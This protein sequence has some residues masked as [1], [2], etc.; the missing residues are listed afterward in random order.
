MR[1]AQQQLEAAELA[2]WAWFGRRIKNQEPSAD[3]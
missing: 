2:A 3:F 1:S